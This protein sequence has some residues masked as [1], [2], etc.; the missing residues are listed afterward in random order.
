MEK[1]I[2]FIEEK[3]GRPVKILKLGSDRFIT[4]FFDW[5]LCNSA[6]TL[7]GATPNE[8]S[9]RCSKCLSVFFIPYNLLFGYG[10]LKVSSRLPRSIFAYSLLSIQ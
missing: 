3:V 6:E 1:T 7:I 8:A 4:E 10:T 5:G 2:R 9:D